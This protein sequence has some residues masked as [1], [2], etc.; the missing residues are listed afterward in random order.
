MSIEIYHILLCKM[1]TFWWKNKDAYYTCMGVM[2]IYHGYNNGHNNPVY[3][4]HKNV[5]VCYTWQNTG[6]FDFY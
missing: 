6:Y 3:N 2:I 5:G 1:H 4:V